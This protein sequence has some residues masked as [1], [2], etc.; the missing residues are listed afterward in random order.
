MIPKEQ[1]LEQ[2]EKEL[3]G[4]VK[5]LD[6]ETFHSTN[7]SFGLN[8]LINAPKSYETSCPEIRKFIDS[9]LKVCG[10]RKTLDGYYR[11]Q[12][13]QYPFEEILRNAI[14]HGNKTDPTLVVSLE[15]IECHSGYIIRIKDSGPGFDVEDKQ[16]AILERKKY[17]HHYG[18]GMKAIFFSNTKITYED[19]GSIWNIVMKK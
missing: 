19:K 17:F 3:G 9:V 13:V 15:L 4:F 14:H 1:S 2:L 6:S 8:P 10:Y 5:L 7:E 12:D 16:R 11:F 18:E